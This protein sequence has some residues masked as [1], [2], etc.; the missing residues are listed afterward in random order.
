M[1][2]QQLVMAA[3][4][5]SVVVAVGGY[6]LLR[7]PLILRLCEAY[8]R[9][10]LRSPDTYQRQAIDYRVGAQ[11][12][13]VAFAAANG[14]GVPVRGSALCIFTDENESDGLPRKSNVMIDGRPLDL[15]TEIRARRNVSRW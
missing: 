5:A 11:T 1:T 15:V 12:V 3:S 13:N 4:G 7:D 14:F 2:R 9:E 6:V 8:T 10:S